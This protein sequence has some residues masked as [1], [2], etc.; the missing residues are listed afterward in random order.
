MLGRLLPPP[1]VSVEAFTDISGEPPL[2]E[3]HHLIARAVESRRREFITSRRCARQAL[4]RLGFPP[5]PI[6]AGARREPRWP[7]GAVGSITHC[8]GYRAAAVART[9]DLAGL[10]IDAEPHGPL[11][12]GVLDLVTTADERDRLLDLSRDHPETHWDRLL[13]SAKES[14]YKAWY[15]LTAR[16]LGFQDARLVFDPD[17]HTFTAHILIDG[18]RTGSGAPLTELAGRYTVARALVVTAVAVDHPA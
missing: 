5:A 12:A 16:W 2:P 3:E 17:T 14:V 7:D 10:G 13:F 1:A 9:T 8:D 11:P 15:P 6:L 18:T 4:A